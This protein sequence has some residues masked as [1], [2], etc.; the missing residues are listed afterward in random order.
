M[1]IDCSMCGR[2]VVI[3]L[4]GSNHAECEKEPEKERT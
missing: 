2:P 3:E 1:M 4:E